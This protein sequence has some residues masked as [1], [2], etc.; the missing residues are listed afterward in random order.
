VGIPIV[1]QIVG[2]PVA[3]AEGVRDTWREVADWIARQ[4][5]ARFGEAVRVEYLDL[6]GPNCPPLPTDAQLPVVLINRKVFSSGGKVNG[7]AICRR[8][9]ALMQTPNV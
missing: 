1:V 5:A 6:F 2:A 8:I 7:P 9:E 3:C 4:L